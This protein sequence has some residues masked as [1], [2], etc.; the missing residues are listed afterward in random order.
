MDVSEAGDE[1]LSVTLIKLKCTWNR[2][3]MA[4]FPVSVRKSGS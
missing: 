3:R 2:N 4:I 1:E